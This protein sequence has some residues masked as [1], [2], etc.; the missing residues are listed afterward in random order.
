MDHPDYMQRAAA[1]AQT[2]RIHAPPNPWVGCVI[3]KNGVIV[4]EGATDRPGGP[5]AEVAALAQAKEQARG[6]AVYVTLEPCAHHGRTPPCCEALAQAGVGNVYIALEDPDPKV[7]GKG[8]AY[9]KS[10]GISV[11]VGL[12]A[13]VVQTILTPYLHHRRHQTPYVVA[14]AGATI[15]GR[16]AAPDGTSQWIT[17]EEARKDA[18]A[19]RA[20]SQAV[21]V[22]VETALKDRPKLTVRD[23]DRLPPEQPLRV[24]LDSQGKLPASHPLISSKTLIATTQ[25]CPEKTL[26]AW[27]SVGAEVVQFPGT[28]GR[29]PL[30]ALL[31]ALAERGVLQLM[32]EGGGEVL[33]SFLEAELINQIVLYLGP[34]VLGEKGLALFGS[35]AVETIEKAPTLRLE[36]VCRLGES[37]KLTYTGTARFS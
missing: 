18:H 22:G 34:R 16:L 29:V 4:G 23:A 17:T 35:Y 21:L 14:K 28:N 20:E 25:A 11:D 30:P 13:E 3:V 15:D 32:L 37:V 31:K 26:S 1:L 27:K 5:H 6:A 7:A 19:L 33:G 12:A 9:L 8:C 36:A 2:A 24:V 10:K